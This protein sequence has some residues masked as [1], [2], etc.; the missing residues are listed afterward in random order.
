MTGKIGSGGNETT[1][2]KDVNKHW[3]NRR[4]PMLFSWENFR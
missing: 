1:A 2:E 3:K 4:G